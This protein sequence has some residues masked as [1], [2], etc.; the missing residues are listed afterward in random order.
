M[1]TPAS[2][3]MLRPPPMQPLVPVHFR[4]CGPTQSALLLAASGSSELHVCPWGA[5]F[6]PPPGPFWKQSMRVSGS[7]PDCEHPTNVPL[8]HATP[9]ASGKTQLA[10]SPQLFAFCMQFQ[11]VFASPLAFLFG[12]A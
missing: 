10:T 7:L 4:A 11:N 6:S 12:F 3:Q 9:P 5:Q 2:S 1:S 8:V